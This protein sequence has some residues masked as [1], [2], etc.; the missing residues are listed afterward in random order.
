[1]AGSDGPED[2]PIHDISSHNRLGR[3][4][5]SS[6][7]CFGSIAMDLIT[8]VD[9]FPTPNSH[10]KGVF[11]DVTPDFSFGGGTTILYASLLTPV[12]VCVDLQPR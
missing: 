8:D 12:A 9:T 11:G 10:Q 6:V 7:I 4:A 3:R 5:R 1:M 2:Y